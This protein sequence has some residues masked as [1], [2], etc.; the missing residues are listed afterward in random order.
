MWKPELFPIWFSYDP[1]VAI[2]SIR[3]H[4]GGY[5]LLGWVV[6]FILSGTGSCTNMESPLERKLK[7]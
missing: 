5:L 1:C 7:H 6:G 4:E 2:V 3:S